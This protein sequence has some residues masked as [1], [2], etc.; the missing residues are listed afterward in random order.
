MWSHQKNAAMECCSF[1]FYDLSSIRELLM[2]FVTVY[3]GAYFYLP[4]D[5]HLQNLTSCWMLHHIDLFRKVLYWLL[6]AD[7]FTP[8][9][10]PFLSKVLA[11]I[12]PINIQKNQ[13]KNKSLIYA[14]NE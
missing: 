9:I 1:P 13:K 7:R 12:F 6:F 4:F 11:L 8:S 14:M 2:L 5:L 3:S 10:S